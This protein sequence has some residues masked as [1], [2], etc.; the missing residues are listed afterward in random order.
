MIHCFTQKNRMKMLSL[1]IATLIIFCAAGFFSL[2]VATAQQGFAQQ[3]LYGLQLGLSQFGLLGNGQTPSYSYNFLSPPINSFGVNNYFRANN[4]FG[5]G[6]GLLSSPSLVGNRLSNSLLRTAH[7]NGATTVF[8]PPSSTN[9]KVS[10]KPGQGIP[11]IKLS[12]LVA[13][14]T[15]YIYPSGYVP[16]API[17]TTI[18]PVTTTAPAA[19]SGMLRQVNFSPYQQ[20]GYS[21]GQTFYS[22]R[23]A[24]P[25]APFMGMG[26]Y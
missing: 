24:T 9:L 5:A 3:G 4:Y 10:I 13:P 26:L 11:G 17:P 20:Q 22:P 23:I 21:L 2:P 14:L 1:S 6:T 15:V 18:A 16:P 19:I 12:A 8:I 25:F 7:I